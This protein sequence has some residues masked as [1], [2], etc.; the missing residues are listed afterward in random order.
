MLRT[1]TS[2]LLAF[3][4]AQSI[5]KAVMMGFSLGGRL[6]LTCME[7]LPERCAGLWLFAP[8]GLV[9]F[10]WYRIAS[11][12]GW[13]RAIYRR[14]VTNPSRVHWLF[15]RARQLR[16]ISERRYQFLKGHTSDVNSVA[17]SPD[18]KRIVSGSHD[19][20]LKVF[21]PHQILSMQRRRD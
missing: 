7:R 15:D 8:D 12:W 6:A 4:D 20:T 10:P 1:F 5:D 19:T 11:K 17:Y 9:R 21:H 18:G 3:M 13:G 14:F 16:L 2:V